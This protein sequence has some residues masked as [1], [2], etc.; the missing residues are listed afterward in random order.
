MVALNFKSFIKSINENPI[1]KPKKAVSHA[2]QPCERGQTQEATGCIPN[3]KDKTNIKKPGEEENNSNIHIHDIDQPINDIDYNSD[4]KFSAADLLNNPYNKPGRFIQA[5]LI[6]TGKKEKVI[7]Y[8]EETGKKEEHEIPIRKLKLK[9]DKEVPPHLQNLIR[10]NWKKIE[11]NLDP[12]ASVLV[13][14]KY[15]NREGHLVEGKILNP[16][17]KQY[18][19]DVL[20]YKIR[21]LIK[22]HQEVYHEIQKSLVPGNPNFFKAITALLIFQTGI[23]P[24]SDADFKGYE[25][26]YGVKL[27]KDNV[28]IDKETGKVAFHI[29]GSIIPI[30]NKQTAKELIRRVSNNLPLFDST[31]WLKSYGATTL[32]GRHIVKKKDGVYVEFV[33]KGTRFISL[34]IKDE[35]LA[36]LLLKRKGHV[37]ENE[38]LIPVNH[39]VLR[40]F[41]S[42]LLNRSEY[43]PKDFRTA[44][45]T[46]HAQKMMLDMPHPETFGEYV[47]SVTKIAHKISDLL[48]NEPRTALEDY[49]DPLIWEYWKDFEF[50][51]IP[52]IKSLNNEKSNEIDDKYNYLPHLGFSVFFGNPTEPPRNW[53]KILNNKKHKK[54]NKKIR[55]EVVA[56]IIGFSPKILHDVNEIK[57][58]PEIPDIH[59]IL[60]GNKK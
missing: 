5:E 45:A 36:N 51:S 56:K 54:I 53:R 38:K 6:D 8:N 2:G 21:E 17:F 57:K 59:K 26:F 10:G 14:G 12:N 34:K 58:T 39:V 25:N 44:F 48:G 60:K 16:K 3:N 43:N 29:K 11:V 47:E 46:M 13:R 20:F 52:T 30:K 42:K 22:R 50:H 7:V 28:S 31:Y 18:N 55:D 1:P 33:G 9:G 37:K 41:T 19:T 4:K 35:Q 49:I 23:R 27:D 15:V 32:E 24:G 40:Q